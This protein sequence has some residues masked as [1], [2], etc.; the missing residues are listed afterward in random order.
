MILGDKSLILE[1]VLS[2]IARKCRQRKGK[3]G[4]QKT[5]NVVVSEAGGSGYEHEVLLACQSTDWWLNTRANIH[6]CSNLNLF[7]YQ[8][9]NGCSVLMG[10]G[11]RVVVQG[12]GRVDLRLTS[13]KTITQ[14][15][16]ACP[17]NK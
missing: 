15:C 3:K 5:T 7:T 1:V 11:S 6:V 13:G 16:A 12:V 14:E 9:A 17:R 2:H 10:N 4:G 8:V